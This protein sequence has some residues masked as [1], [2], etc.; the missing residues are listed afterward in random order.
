MRPGDRLEIRVAQLQLNRSR[1]KSMLANSARDLFREVRQRRFEP[2]RVARIFTE[3]M[4]VADR[5]RIGPFSDLRIEP[6]AGIKPLRLSGQRKP[7]FAKPR[8]EI[9][10][11]HLGKISDAP[12]SDTVQI[13]L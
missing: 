6:S 10:L 7:P 12:D 2:F 13:A 11:A 4:L 9:F 8:F 5:F 3:R 1:V